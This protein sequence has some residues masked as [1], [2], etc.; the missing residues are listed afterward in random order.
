LLPLTTMADRI[1]ASG[2]AMR[3]SEGGLGRKFKSASPIQK[4]SG[5]TLIELL[6]VIAIIAILAAMLLPGLS[7]A[8]EKANRTSCINNMRNL[9]LAM[10]MYTS[11]NN[12]SMPWCQW[13][14]DYGPSWIYMPKPNHTAPDPFSLVGLL[15]ALW[16]TIPTIFRTSNK[17][18]TTL[19]SAI[20][21][22]II[23]RWIK[24]KTWT[25]FIAFNEFPVTS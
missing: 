11:D 10:A 17:V 23:V 5:F 12:D 24:R 20:G 3:F 1:A 6:V 13:D 18:C 21:R 15:G 19:T 2:I 8:K 9:G 16:W 14:N 22:F 7:R 25:S 4:V